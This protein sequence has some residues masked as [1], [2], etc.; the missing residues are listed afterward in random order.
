MTTPHAFGYQSARERMIATQLTPISDVRVLQAMLRVPRHLFVPEGVRTRA[1]EDTPLPI[2]YGQTISQPLMVA[3]VLEAAKLNRFDRVLEVG[4][5]SGYQA[6]L[7]AQ[8]AH[9]VYSIEIIPEL[10]NTARRNLTSAEISRVRVI[11][12]DGSLGWAPAAPFNVIIVAAGASQ[13][14]SPLLQQLAMGGRL[15]I[16]LGARPHQSLTRVMRTPAG[17]LFDELDHCAFVPL[18]GR[19]GMTVPA[20][21][22][23]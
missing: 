13:V 20:P 22:S 16:P 2:G 10:A 19:H 1:Y 12:A 7:I 9:D 21:A 14:P 15:L 5:G 8:L 23:C 17:F 3:L 6:G 4:T 18:L 11:T